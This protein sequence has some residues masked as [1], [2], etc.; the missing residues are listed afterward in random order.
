VRCTLIVMSHRPSSPRPQL[1]KA[2][3]SFTVS[4]PIQAPAAAYA[5]VSVRAS[6]CVRVSVCV[7]DLMRQGGDAAEQRERGGTVSRHVLGAHG[8][9]CMCACVCACVR[10]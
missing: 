9:V 7:L 3:S 4:A 8:F 10:A 1:T 2:V 5:H 6:C